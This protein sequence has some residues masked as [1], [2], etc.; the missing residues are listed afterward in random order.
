MFGYFSERDFDPEG[1]RGEYPNPAFMRMSE[2]DG[3]WAARIIAH[4]RP[5]HVSAAVRA[6]S[7][8]RPEHASYLTRILLLRQHTLLRRYLSKLSPLADV[9]PRR[10]QV[11]MVDLA[12][13]T[14]TFSAATFHY[15]A[16]V[17]RAL[18]AE[19]QTA[20]QV[21]SDGRVCVD[22]PSSPGADGAS[23]RA[24]RARYVVVRVDN[25]TGGGALVLHLYD[26]GRLEPMYLAGI[27]RPEK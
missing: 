26:A 12:R 23:P 14:E 3:A 9:E 16:W 7:L 18:G 21:L 27:E 17:S 20:V 8:T 6:G 1:W 5:E 25:G 15:R 10:G 24:S 22:L 13:R 2:R 4:F 19:A 11:C